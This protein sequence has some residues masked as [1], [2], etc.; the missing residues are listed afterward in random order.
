MGFAS[1]PPAEI[2]IL[3]SDV[4]GWR[5][6]EPQGLFISWLATRV[7]GAAKVRE[8]HDLAL[9]CSGYF[10]RNSGCFSQGPGK[11]VSTFVVA[12]CRGKKP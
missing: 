12:E 3:A 4:R 11:Q 8:T 7:A 6:A 5:F 9:R 2:N 10:Q 1:S